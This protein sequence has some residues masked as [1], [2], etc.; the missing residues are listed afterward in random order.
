[1]NG[2]E[3]SIEG[4]ITIQLHMIDGQGLN[5]AST[6]PDQIAVTVYRSKGGIWYSNNWDGTNSV[7]TNLCKA[8]DNLSVT[9]SG[10]SSTTSTATVQQLAAAPEQI[11]LAQAAKFNL[12]AFP[13][14]SA[15]YFNVKLESSNA[16]ERITLRVIDL[17]GRVVR[18]MQNLTAGQT[19]QLGSEYRPG[20]Y[21]VEMIQGGNRKQLQLIKRI[22]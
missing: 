12:T 16:T 18:L 2:V 22:N 19:V 6:S 21:F 20:V 13:N 5:P 1:V 8:G 9:G 11:E 7:L 10:V 15:S 14:P 3:Q 4:N 17:Q